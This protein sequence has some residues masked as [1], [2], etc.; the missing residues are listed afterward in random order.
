[1][2][3]QKVAAARDLIDREVLM[4]A[5]WRHYEAC[6]GPRPRNQSEADKVLKIAGALLAERVAN[7]PVSVIDSVFDQFAKSAAEVESQPQNVAT[8]LVDKVASDERCIDAA[9]TL[10][11]YLAS[12]QA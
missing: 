9:S 5:F 1:M 12:I 8:K 4:P 3:E 11:E 10:A 7:Q 6:G 2:D